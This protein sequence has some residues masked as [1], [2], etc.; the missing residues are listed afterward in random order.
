[1]KH[2]IPKIQSTPWVDWFGEYS[3]SIF[4]ETEE[5]PGCYKGRV[6]GRLRASFSVIC[7]WHDCVDDFF[8]APEHISYYLDWD[9]DK[10]KFVRCIRQRDRKRKPE[11]IWI[12]RIGGTK[13]IE[14]IPPRRLKIPP[15]VLECLTDWLKKK[16][17]PNDFTLRRGLYQL[18][19]PY[20][21]L[22]NEMFSL[23]R[24]RR[25]NQILEGT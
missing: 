23:K 20:E 18:E 13:V 8:D 7:D 11:Q 6:K 2:P 17:F 4:V 22:C 5:L 16:S 9:F 15:L 24:E 1:M 12:N 14:Y 19:W 10:K 3:E 21:D 25:I